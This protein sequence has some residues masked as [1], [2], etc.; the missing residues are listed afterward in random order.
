VSFHKMKE[1]NLERGNTLLIP[2]YETSIWAG[3]PTDPPDMGRDEFSEYLEIPEEFVKNPDH[4]YAH[5]V[6]GDSMEPTLYEGDKLLIDCSDS[7]KYSGVIGKI[8]LVYMD[9]G[10]NVKRL[11]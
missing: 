11:Q 4:T 6:K 8:V 3:T 2:V 5:R 10:F 7:A 1:P 9:G